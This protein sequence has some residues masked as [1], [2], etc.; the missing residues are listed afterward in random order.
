MTGAGV[1]NVVCA[2]F[3]GCGPPAWVVGVV[4]LSFAVV[5]IALLVKQRRTSRGEGL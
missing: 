2:G 4:G 5:C 1:D 3:F